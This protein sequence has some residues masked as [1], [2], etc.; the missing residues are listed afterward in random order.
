MD[1][2]VV[3]GK[4]KYPI[5]LK[6]KTSPSVVQKGI[7]QLSDY[8]TTLDENIGWLV[9]FDRSKT[10]GWVDKISW[11]TEYIEGKLIYIVGC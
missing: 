6:M 1:L 2:C 3:Y 9:V 4:N 8:M 7:E 11:K 5:A 10:K